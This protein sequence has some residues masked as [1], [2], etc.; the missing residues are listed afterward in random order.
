MFLEALSILYSIKKDRHEA[1]DSYEVRPMSLAFV[2]SEQV[3]AHCACVPAP[4]RHRSR[5]R[6]CRCLNFCLCPGESCPSPVCLQPH[7]LGDMARRFPVLSPFSWHSVPF[8]C[9][10]FQISLYNTFGRTAIFSNKIYKCLNS[11]IL[12]AMIVLNDDVRFL[13]ELGNASKFFSSLID[14]VF[15]HGL[16]IIL[17]V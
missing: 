8:S 4:P 12:L 1:G 7:L 2:V 11:H 10:F 3:S 9:A 13:V 17:V 14:I 6:L 5:C 16:F 15:K